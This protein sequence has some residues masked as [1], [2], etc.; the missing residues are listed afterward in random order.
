MFCNQCGHKNKTNA[1]FCR[2]CGNKLNIIEKDIS[3]VDFYGNKIKSKNTVNNPT[4]KKTSKN[5]KSLGKIV[6]G[7]FTALSVPLGIFLFA[8]ARI[9]LRT[10]I[11]YWTNNS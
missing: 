2:K 9:S 11:R 1:N 7:I 10:L 8:V 6:G 5:S 3:S 4:P